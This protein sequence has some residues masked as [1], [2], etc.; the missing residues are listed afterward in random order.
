MRPVWRI[1]G[2]RARMAVAA[3]AVTVVAGCGEKVSHESF[4][5]GTSVDRVESDLGPATVTLLPSDAGDT[6]VNVELRYTG[7]APEVG[8]VLE[9]TT[10]YL[11]L[12]CPDEEV[13]DGSFTVFAPPSLSAN[14]NSS[15]GDIVA[16]AIDGV[17]TSTTDTGTVDLDDIGGSVDIHTAS[18]PV[19]VRGVEGSLTATSHDAE[20]KVAG[21]GG[22]LDLSSA[23]GLLVGTDLRSAQ[24]MAETDSGPI[25]LTWSEAPEQVELESVSGEVDLVVPAGAY[26]VIAGSTTGEVTVTGVSD[27]PD[28]TRVLR[29]TTEFG[30]ITITGV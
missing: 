4:D 16:E 12:L 3:L 17:V 20:L 13:C 24:G 18:G 29:V 8:V 28:A 10:L 26:Q 30:N 7:E 1:A 23:L 9:G 6:R 27:E 5:L 11:T 22:D 14:L 25:Y 2:R 19:D 15:S 21:V